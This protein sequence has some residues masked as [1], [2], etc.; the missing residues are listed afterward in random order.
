MAE[1]ITFLDLKTGCFYVLLL[2]ISCSWYVSIV[3]QK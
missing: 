2:Y 1:N 3:Q